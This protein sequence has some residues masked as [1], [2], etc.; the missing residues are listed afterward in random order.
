MAI[1]YSNIVHCNCKTLQNL[2]KLGYVNENM[3]SG[4]PA[5]DLQSK[6]RCQCRKTTFIISIKKYQVAHPSYLALELKV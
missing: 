4:N 2:P 5:L 6:H 3:P 1:K